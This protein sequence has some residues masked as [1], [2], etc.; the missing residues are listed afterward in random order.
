MG[1][2]GRVSRWLSHPVVEKVVDT[3]VEA[4]DFR[5]KLKA[6]LADDSKLDRIELLGLLKEAYDIVKAVT[7]KDE[8]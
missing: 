5:N 8:E 6:A 1:F 3:T 2:W 4:V 7:G